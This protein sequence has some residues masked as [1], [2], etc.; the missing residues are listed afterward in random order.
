MPTATDYFYPDFVCEL[1][2]GR[3]LVVEYKGEHLM[4]EET[5]EKEQIGHQWERSSDGRCLFLL[6]RKE[7][8]HGRDVGQQIAQKIQRV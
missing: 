4:N 2:D 8:D 6:A 1:A 5:S 3:L 7:N